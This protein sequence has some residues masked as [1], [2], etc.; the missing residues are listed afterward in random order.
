[1]VAQLLVR[2]AVAMERIEVAAVALEH[3]VAVHHGVGLA[4]Q[5]GSGGAVGDITLPAPAAPPPPP[6]PRSVESA[7]I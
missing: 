2:L 7:A 3:G 1:M 5:R 4:A 6:S